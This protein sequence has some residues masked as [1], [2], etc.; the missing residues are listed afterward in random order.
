LIFYSKDF[1]LETRIKS[2]IIKEKIIMTIIKVDLK[3]GDVA[4]DFC[5]PNKD[6]KKV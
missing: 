1:I 3:V 6:N 5:L 2:K 4:P